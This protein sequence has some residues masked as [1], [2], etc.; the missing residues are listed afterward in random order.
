MF[1]RL[2]SF[3][4]G[5]M[6][7][8]VVLG[9]TLVG[10]IA[11]RRMREQSR[12]AARAVRSRPGGAPRSRCADSR[13]RAHDGRRALRQPASGRRRRR[14]RDR[15]RVPAG[16]DA[17]RADPLALAVPA[18][19]LRGREHPVVEGGPRQR[20]RAAGDRG[21]WAPAAPALAAGGRGARR[22]T[23]GQR[24]AAVRRQPQRD[25]RHADG[26]GVRARQPR[27][28]GGAGDRDR[29][30][31]GRRSGCSACTSR[32][33]SAASSPS[34]SRPRWSRCCC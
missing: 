15:D 12:E 20:E 17:A 19:E 14:Q 24:D 27:A 1:F 10:V 4:L 11:G 21:R 7:F 29:R 2:T 23:D 34:S 32:S 3:E 25:D 28:A 13:V 9:T 26:Q 30:C 6:V 22:I 31:S 5:L 18:D 16:A 8:A 33:S